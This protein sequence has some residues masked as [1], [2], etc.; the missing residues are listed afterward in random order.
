LAEMHGGS[1]EAKS[2]GEGQGSAFIVRLPILST[3]AGISPPDGDTPA[4]SSAKRRILI[5]DDNKDSADSLAL[6]LEITGNKTYMA[7]DGVEAF[8]AIE[9]HRPEVVLLDIGLPKLD[10]HEVCRRVREQPWGKDIMVI[11]LTGWGQE[12]DRR[13]SE[14]AGFNGHL[15]KP[16]DYDKL[17]ELLG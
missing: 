16:I 9:K 5:V 15:V 4:A 2:A 11:A 6:L 14:E 13:K 3:P 17:L 7:H 12:D 1:I 8:E 10:G